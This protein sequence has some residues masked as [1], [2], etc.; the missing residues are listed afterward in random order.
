MRSV[1]ASAIRCSVANVMSTSSVRASAAWAAVMATERPVRIMIE[2]VATIS[3]ATTASAAD[4]SASVMPARRRAP[5]VGA[6]RWAGGRVM[7]SV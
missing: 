6:G 2:P 5:G 1:I 4:S 3:V 7:F